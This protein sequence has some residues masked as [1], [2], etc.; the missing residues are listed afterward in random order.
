M[1]C[2]HYRV[3]S[4]MIRALVSSFQM[5]RAW[6]KSGSHRVGPQQKLVKLNY[7][8]LPSPLV[9]DSKG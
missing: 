6:S 9:L 8:P 2:G 1:L 3:L 7:F 5:P 4:K